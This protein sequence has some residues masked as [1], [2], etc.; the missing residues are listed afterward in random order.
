MSRSAEYKRFSGFKRALLGLIIPALM[1]V[2]GC[3]QLPPTELPAAQLPPQKAVEDP[4]ELTRLGDQAYSQGQFNEA[5]HL[6]KT[7]TV[8]QPESFAAW[9]KLGNASLHQGLS[10]QAERAYL[11]ALKH[12]SSDPKAWYN[13]ATA[14]LMNAR[15]AILGAAENLQDSDPARQLAAQRLRALNELIFKNLGESAAQTETNPETNPK[16]SPAV[17]PEANS[18][19]ASDKPRPRS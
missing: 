6:Y 18:S 14:R 16:V 19:S 10:D 17:S 3:A 11:E 2:Q 8:I 5:Q 15:R 7:L 13:L 1:L 4:I 12:D 9:F